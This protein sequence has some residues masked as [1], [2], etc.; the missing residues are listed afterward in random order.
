[1]N[2][3]LLVAR[4]EYL[5]NLRR[6]AFLFGAF[7][8]PIFTIGI[9]ILVFALQ[10]GDETDPESLGQIGYVD[11]AGVLAQAIDQPDYFVP[12]TTDEEARAALDSGQ[13][14]GYFVVPR[15][16]LV[17]GALR[18]FSAETLPGALQ[19]EIRTFLAA[20]LAAQVEGL[21]VPVERLVEPLDLTIIAQD[22]GR[23]LTG[24]AIGGL[25]IVPFLFVFVFMMASQVTS[26]FLMSGVVEEKTS[27]IMEILVTSITPLQM[28]MGK[29]LGLGA[30][31]LTQF[32]VWLG[33]GLLILSLQLEFLQGITIPLD[34]AFIGFVLFLL[35]YFL[36]ATLMAGIGAVAGSEEESRQYA[37]ILGIV[38][39]IPFF[40]IVQFMTNPN[41]GLPVFLSLFPFTAGTS[42]LLR[43]AFSSVPL[44][45]I[46]LC[47][48]LLF[49]SALFIAFASAR[50]FRWGLLMYGKRI[51]F[52]EL[53]RVIRTPEPA[54]TTVA[55]G[56]A[57]E[58]L[59][60]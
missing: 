5:Y 22:S 37:G 31:G 14:G 3:M 58:S 8:V 59:G 41:E 54:A 29:I 24:A 57:V 16:Y 45:Q 56:E 19:A 18:F 15:N 13:I 27:R 34:M 20:N 1:M 40:F 4:R 7:V 60:R 28:L 53:W 36:V 42:M 39:A 26:G 52:R 35:S 50:V 6:P 21:Q 10:I 49:F 30:L 23:E 12:F 43:Y 46:G 51:N 47:F 25:F 17:V 32:L 11:N 44:W 2:K 38:S 48:A 55:H 33:G 9:L